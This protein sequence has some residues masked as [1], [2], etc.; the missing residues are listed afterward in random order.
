MTARETTALEMDGAML[1]HDLPQLPAGALGWALRYPSG[2]VVY[3]DA[4]VQ[5]ADTADVAELGAHRL[6][7]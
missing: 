6:A 5:D 7:T 2:H 4:R 3:L 1:V